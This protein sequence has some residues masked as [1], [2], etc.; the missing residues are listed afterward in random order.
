MGATTIWERWDSMLPDGTI[1]PG[2]M[3]S[4]NHYAL[5]AVADWMHRVLGGLAPGAPGY[6]VINVAP[7][8]GGGVAWASTAHLTPLRPGRGLLAAGGWQPHCRRRRA[9]RQ[10]GR[11][12]VAWRC[13]CRVGPGRHGFDAAYRAPADDPVWRPPFVPADFE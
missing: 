1:N 12:D 10:H 2:E 5:G 11:C 8:P 7:R 3:T 9:R 13:S 6:R 4:F